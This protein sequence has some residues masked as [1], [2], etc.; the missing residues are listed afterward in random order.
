VSASSSLAPRVQGWRV[1]DVSA[2]QLGEPVDEALLVG[3]RKAGKLF[4]Q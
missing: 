4:C 2:A 1:Q 3:F